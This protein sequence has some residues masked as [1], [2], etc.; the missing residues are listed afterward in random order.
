MTP[1][2]EPPSDR[3]RRPDP[4][5]SC[6]TTPLSPA[7]LRHHQQRVLG[8]PSYT[9]GMPARLLFWTADKVFPHGRSFE[10]FAF[11]ELVARV[12]YMAWEHLA[13][14]PRRKTTATT[15]SAARSRT[16][17]CSPATNRTTSSG[18]C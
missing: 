16:G 6:F 5:E 17:W 18:T 8:V 11:V 13:T 10:F 14:S 9:Y 12:P 4:Y 15:P 1:T 2:P 3:P 7:E